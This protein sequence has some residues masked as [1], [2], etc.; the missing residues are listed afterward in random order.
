MKLSFYHITLRSRAQTLIHS[1]VKWSYIEKLIVKAELVDKGSRVR[2]AILV[3]LIYAAET[4]IRNFNL[5]VIKG[6]Q[7]ESPDAEEERNGKC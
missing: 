1:L 3:G 7:V 6:L 4:K 2:L 5:L